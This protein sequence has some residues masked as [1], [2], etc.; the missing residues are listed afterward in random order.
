MIQIGDNLLRK[1]CENISEIEHYQEAISSPK[2]WCCHHRLE[3]HTSEG[4]QIEY[5]NITY[6]RIK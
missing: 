6:R 4:N 1:C 2:R 5:E 3:T